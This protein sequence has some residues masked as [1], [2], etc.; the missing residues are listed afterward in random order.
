MCVPLL[1]GA[2]VRQAS[3]S[4]QVDFTNHNVLLPLNT[5]LLYED[6]DGQEANGIHAFSSLFTPYRPSRVAM[7]FSTLPTFYWQLIR[8]RSMPS[9]FKTL[10]F[11]SWL[12]FLCPGSC[13]MDPP[14]CRSR[15]LQGL[16]RRR[17]LGARGLF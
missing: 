3:T 2:G 14:R 15:V 12:A 9:S 11:V 16:L 17:H 1:D 8:P 5:C 4:F 13:S 10:A 7:S 6:K